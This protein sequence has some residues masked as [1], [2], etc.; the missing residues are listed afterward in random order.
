M[1]LLIKIAY[2]ALGIDI[3]ILLVIFVI[4]IRFMFID[5]KTDSRINEFKNN[6][7][8]NEPEKVEKICEQLTTSR[9]KTDQYARHF[10]LALLDIKN[11][12]F[13]HA[14]ENL[15]KARELY[16]DLSTTYY[17]TIDILFQQK[18]FTKAYSFLMKSVYHNILFDCKFFTYA[19]MLFLSSESFEEAINVFELA[20]KKDSNSPTPH[21]GI[22]IAHY[23]NKNNTLTIDAIRTA[24]KKIKPQNINH[25][26]LN[27]WAKGLLALIHGDLKEAKYIFEYYKETSNFGPV[28]ELILNRINKLLPSENKS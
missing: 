10:G 14:L 20:E 28:F 18:Q 8:K 11:K 2:V 12:E 25:N 19:G 4:F 1:D 23:L 9:K 13:E 7:E 17:K 6:L 26:E 22:A 27:E 15:E 5:M 16:P 21:I 3:L 24:R